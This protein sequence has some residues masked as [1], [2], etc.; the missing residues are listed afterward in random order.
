MHKLSHIFQV[1]PYTNYSI[2]ITTTN[3]NIINVSFLD[4]AEFG[5]ILIENEDNYTFNYYF[6]LK[7]MA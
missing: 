3:N 1:E 7:I 5:A 4:D 6:W 2:T